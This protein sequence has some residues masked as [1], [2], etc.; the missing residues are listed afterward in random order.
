MSEAL[1]LMDDQQGPMGSANVKHLCRMGLS[2]AGQVTIDG[3]YAYLGY[4]YG[5]EG[6]SILDISDPRNP[7]MLTTI[8][9]DNKR[10]HSHKVRVVGDIMVVNSEERPVTGEPYDDGGFRIYDIK[11]K[12]NPKLIHF[13]KTFGK[14]VHRFDM[15]DKYA[16]ISTEMEGFVGNILVIYDMSDPS[17]PEEVSRWWMP[18]QNV[19]AGEEP[20]PLGKEH[21]LHHAL[22]CGDKMYAGCWGSGYAIIDI[23]DIK[24]PKTLDM[25]DVHPPALEP[26]HTLL[27]IPNP[28]G[29]RE[30]A[31]ATDEER[32]NRHGDEGKPHAPLYVFDVTDPTAM[33]LL[34]TYHV[35]EEA[36]PYHGVGI[37]F[38]AHQFREVI[39]NNTAFVTWFAAGLRILNFDN[40]E[41][42]KEIGYFI[43]EPGERQMA[44]ATNDVEMD[45]RGLLYIT[46][47]ASGFDV[48]EFSG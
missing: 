32:S 6:T 47:K 37:R 44:P 41:Q 7:K 19:A 40:P 43:P 48:I 4:M 28:I 16:Y 8:M 13:Q 33:K 42:P 14:G 38:G 34:H 26:S 25:Y 5:P 12:S 11:D 36:S 1:P 27:K 18:G 39:E 35:P 46:D 24:N 29:G 23:S 30:I 21:R 22:R 31:L 10:S 3:N 9:L 2:G 15:D 17:R 20:H 45:D